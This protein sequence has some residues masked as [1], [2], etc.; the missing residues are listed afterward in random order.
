[1]KKI[2]IFFTVIGLLISCSKEEDNTV[3]KTQE[4]RINLSNDLIYY[5]YIGKFEEED[6][7]PEITNQAQHF[8]YSD[9][10]IYEDTGTV[11]YRYKPLSEY[12]GEDY[13]EILSEQIIDTETAQ[14]QITTIKLTFIIL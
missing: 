5:Y 6:V 14:K 10:L 9:L 1:M 2:L 8:E 4:I 13:V 12:V 3:Y 7:G 11:S